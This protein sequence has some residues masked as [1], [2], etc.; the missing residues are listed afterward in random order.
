M[1]PEVPPAAYV[2]AMLQLSGMGPAR[3]ALLLRDRTPKDAWRLITERR[4]APLLGASGH[5]LPNVAEWQTQAKQIDLAKLYA[6]HE[7][8]TLM[9][10]GSDTYPRRLCDDIEA[11]EMLFGLGRCTLGNSPTVAVVGTRRCTRY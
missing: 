1:T 9:L 8:V 2:I 3:L 4:A 6:A 5:K 7:S 11:P 10:R